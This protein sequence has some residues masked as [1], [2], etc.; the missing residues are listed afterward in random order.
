MDYSKEALQI[1]LLNANWN[2]VITSENF[3]WSIVKFQ[4][5]IFFQLWIIWHQLKK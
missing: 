3:D 5:N 1:E 4:I 2:L